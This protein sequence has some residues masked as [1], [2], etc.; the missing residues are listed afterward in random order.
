M[1][2]IFLFFAIL[3]TTLFAS[4]SLWLK[5]DFNAALQQAK[6]VDKPILMM[7]SAKT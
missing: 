7:Y 2:K 1:R 6:K 4:D 5:H 3:A